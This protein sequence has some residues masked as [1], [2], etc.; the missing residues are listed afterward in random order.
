MRTRA[1]RHMLALELGRTL[2]DPLTI[3]GMFA[4]V[5]IL[6]LGAYLHWR[7]L[8]PR[9]QNGRLFGEAYLLAVMIAWHAGIARDRGS[10]FDVYL[11]ANFVDARALYFAKV[12]AALVFVLVLSA[13]AF[14]VAA[15]TSA[16]DIGYAGHY[17]GLFLLA[18]VVSL[19]ALVLVELALNTRYPVP[20]LLLLFF[21]LLAVYSRVADVR[22]LLRSLGMDGT[23][24]ALPALVRC[25]AALALT[26]AIYPLFRLRL[27]ARRLATIGHAP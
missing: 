15:G 6:L 8:P 13:F 18:S 5:L 14:V 11:A 21:A 27:G 1:Y 9:P 20:V 3:A 12:T 23:L 26:A 24:E 7:A 17:A 4:F 22:A 16:G 25:A 2:R 19:P 10:R